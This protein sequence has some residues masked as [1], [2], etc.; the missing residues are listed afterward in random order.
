M[1][2]LAQSKNTTLIKVNFMRLR[3]NLAPAIAAPDNP[4]TARVAVNRAWM[5]HFGEARVNTQD[6]LGAKSENPTPFAP[7]WCHH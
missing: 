3:L 4:L 7:Q 1:R 5:H 6:D 2:Y